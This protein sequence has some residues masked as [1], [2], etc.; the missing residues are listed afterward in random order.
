VTKKDWFS[1]LFFILLSIYVCWESV[2]LRFGSFSKPG[3]GFFSFLAGLLL[4]AL[5][6]IVFLRAWVS[7]TL[8]EKIHG[9]RIPWKP[10]LIAFGS[11]LGFTLLLKTLGFNITTLLF[12]GVIL[13]AVEKKRWIV[14]IG[15]A[16]CFAVG[17][18]IVFKLGLQSQLPEGPFGFFGF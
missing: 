4:G 6:V 5:G 9:E 1:A 16:L 18:Y 12:L 2:G 10:L 7:K 8:R 13:R 15:V 3:P 11:L 17:A 14:S